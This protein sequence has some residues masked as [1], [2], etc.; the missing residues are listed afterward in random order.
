MLCTIKKTTNTGKSYK[1]TVTF[2]TSKP[3]KVLYFDNP[4]MAEGYK[5]AVGVKGV[6]PQIL[7]STIQSIEIEEMPLQKHNVRGWSVED[8]EMVFSYDDDEYG[9]Y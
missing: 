6:D 9:F 7:P 3:Q 2:N 5:H 1:V 8:G 4:E